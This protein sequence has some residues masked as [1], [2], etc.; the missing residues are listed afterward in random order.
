MTSTTI[1]GGLNLV[2]LG[3]DN[4]ACNLADGLGKA[5]AGD[6]QVVSGAERL[7]AEGT[8]KLVEGGN[9]TAGV[10]AKKYATLVALGEK[11]ADGALPYG[12]PTGSTG[13]AAYQLTLAAA[14]TASHDNAT[15]ALAALALLGAACAVSWF[16]G[17]RVSAR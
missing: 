14:T 17:R 6:K 5:A 10:N 1:Q 4:P 15:R 13:S 8:S 7:R 3:L 11:A 16:L 9:D 12:A 2:K